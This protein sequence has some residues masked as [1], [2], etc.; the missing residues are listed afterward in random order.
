MY[1]VAQLSCRRFPGVSAE[2]RRCVHSGIDVLLVQETYC[3]RGE[4]KD[5]EAGENVLIFGGFVIIVNY[6]GLVVFGPL[7]FSP[8]VEVL[9]L[10][11]HFG[12]AA[13]IVHRCVTTSDHRA[14][15]FRVLPEAGLY[16]SNRD[17]AWRWP[18][19]YDVR[20]TNWGRFD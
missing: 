7:Y 2:L 1:R 8:S 6:Q 16:R 12:Q 19:R 3:L 10:L 20:F 5:I 14:I 18:V 17:V 15:K 9:P 11:D 13:F 4:V